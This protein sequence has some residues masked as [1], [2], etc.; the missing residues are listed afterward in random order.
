MKNGQGV[1]GQIINQLKFIIMS[2]QSYERF[3]KTAKSLRDCVR[4]I[5]DGEFQ[6]LGSTYEVQGLKELLELAEELLAYKH[7][8]RE[9]IEEQ[10]D[11][12]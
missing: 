4:A 5:E 3:E 11:L 7:E 2:Y 9:S 6:D 8:I 10:E 1:L 12:L